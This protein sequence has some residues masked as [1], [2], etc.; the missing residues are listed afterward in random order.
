MKFDLIDYDKESKYK[1]F[2][3][4]IINTMNLKNDKEYYE[5]VLD[6]NK[7]KS[8]AKDFYKYAN[9]FIDE[10]YNTFESIDNDQISAYDNKA[11]YLKEA[12]TLY[13]YDKLNILTDAVRSHI[14]MENS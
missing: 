2:K 6:S 3:K 9:Q 14:A 11:E 10:I 7:S 1:A 13:L 12:K 4:F 8:S 5:F